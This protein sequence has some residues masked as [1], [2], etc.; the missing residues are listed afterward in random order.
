MVT[1][2]TDAND[3]HYATTK[4]RTE[5][6]VQWSELEHRSNEEVY[7]FSFILSLC[8]GLPKYIIMYHRK[9]HIHLHK[10]HKKNY[11]VRFFYFVVKQYFKA[12]LRTK[13]KF[14]YWSKL[15]TNYSNWNLVIWEKNSHGKLISKIHIGI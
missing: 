7:S 15:Q 4:A 8:M 1:N 12:N 2:K 14:T 3:G 11:F 5:W 10:I 9:L 6:G 13:I